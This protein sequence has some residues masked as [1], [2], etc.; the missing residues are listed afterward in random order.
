M[1]TGP[2]SSP[3]TDSLGRH[4]LRRAAEPGVSRSD[5]A[6]GIQRRFAG[7]GGL[8]AE[9]Q[10]R[11]APAAAAAWENGAGLPYFGFGGFGA[12]ANETM[13]AMPM[14]RTVG[15]TAVSPAAQSLSGLG[16]I[17]QRRH[18]GG[19]RASES[20]MIQ[21]RVASQSH[22]AG[23]LGDPK[24][25]DLSGGKVRPPRSFPLAGLALRMTLADLPATEEGSGSQG[26]VQRMAT[27]PPSPSAVVGETPPRSPSLRLPS[28]TEMGP[29]IVR[30]AAGRG[31]VQRR[32]LAQPVATAG[33]AMA[34]QSRPAGGLFPLAG[35]ALRMTPADLSATEAGAPPSP[36]TAVGETPSRSSSL[37][38]LPPGTEMGPPIVRRAAGRGAVQRRSLAQPVA[39]AGGAMA[40]QS[41][42]AGG[43]GDS[44]DLGGG[45]VPLSRSFPLAGLALRMTPAD[46]LPTVEGPR[47]QGL[48]Q[49]LA[50]APPSPS[51]AL[52]ETPSPPIVNRA[53]ARGTVQRMSLTQPPSAG[54]LDVVTE[55]PRRSDLVD[56]IRP[57]RPIRPAANAAIA[58]LPLVQPR[59]LTAGSGEAG[60]IQF[61]RTAGIPIQRTTDSSPAPNTELPLARPAG[62]V[63]R[64]LNGSALGNTA[65][66]EEPQSLAANNLLAA[67]A[68]AEKIDL[69]DVVERVMRRLTRSLAVESER[70]GGRQ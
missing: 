33:G 28:G 41:H 1:T 8:A 20:G 51:V 63:Q 21:R 12:A 36:S 70:H 35:L 26:L 65:T 53:A 7:G 29:P 19:L 6:A 16:A 11:W 34:P 31:A 49:R 14:A 42:P 38:L 2:A 48:V 50:T 43:L 52:R 23:S 45:K 39:T 4:L 57:R 47:S 5:L 27:A 13:H 32:S 61:R 18:L 60:I 55:S 62:V 68:P 69:D 9:I 56:P 64:E 66:Q 40:P 59:R 3:E 44:R 25:L 24:D 15:A 10:R 54:P 17:L 46:V 37:R 67:P 58:A 22:P 30:R